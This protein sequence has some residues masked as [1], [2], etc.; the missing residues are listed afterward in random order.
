MPC[1]QYSSNEH[2]DSRIV[3][4]SDAEIGETPYIASL[5]R[6]GGHFCG[7]TVVTNQWLLT[8]GHCICKLVFVNTINQMIFLIVLFGRQRLK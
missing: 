8:A 1:L 7:A 6:R 4:G 3:G 5:T 2:R